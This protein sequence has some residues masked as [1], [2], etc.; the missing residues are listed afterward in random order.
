MK[1]VLFLNVSWLQSRWMSLVFDAIV[2]FDSVV[3]LKHKSL[4]FADKIYKYRLS[5]QYLF[6]SISSST[7]R[8]ETPIFYS[9]SKKIDDETECTSQ[10]NHGT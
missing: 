6:R 2:D 1:I 7:G 3:N 5:F 8:T 9:L 10:F 4:K